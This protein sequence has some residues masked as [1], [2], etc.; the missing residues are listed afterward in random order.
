MGLFE[1][2]KLISE[3]EKIYKKIK[4]DQLEKCTNLKKIFL[5]YSKKK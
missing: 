3:L 2:L 4:N 5:I 1:F